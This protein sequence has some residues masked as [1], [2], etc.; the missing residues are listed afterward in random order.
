MPSSRPHSSLPHGSSPPLPILTSLAEEVSPIAESEGEEEQDQLAFTIDFPSRPHLQI[1]ENIL[2]TGKPL[3]GYCQ[4]DPL[5]SLLAAVGSPCTN[6]VKAP[7]NCK[8]LPNSPRCTNCPAKKTCSLGKILRYWY[9]AR[10]CN[11]D[12]A[13]SRRFLELH[14][15]PMHHVTWVIPLETWQQ[16]NAN[17]HQCTSSTTILLELNMLD[18]QD[19]DVVDWQELRTY[20]ALQ[21]EEAAIAAKRKRNR[22]PLPVVG[23]SCKKTTGSE[24]PKR[25]PCHKHLTLEASSEPAPC[26]QL[27]IP[28]G[29]AVAVPPTIFPC[30]SPFPMEVPSRDC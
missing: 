16:Y 15:T 13:Y 21:Q 29:C 18:D 12:L 8:V 20:L 5:W 25:R 4:D 28:P 14:G 3:A 11:Q 23:P 22:S 24:V 7:H 26:V 9:F 19:V 17:L 2:N 1:F 10:R 6:C 27:L 30:A